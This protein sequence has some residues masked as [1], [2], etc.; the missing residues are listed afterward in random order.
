MNCWKA[1][2]ICWSIGGGIALAQSDRAE[3]PTV[4][5]GA[6]SRSAARVS[7]GAAQSAVNKVK[8]VRSRLSRFQRLLSLSAE[9]RENE[10]E[11]KSDKER[12]F[13]RR[14]LEKY[15]QMAKEDRETALQGLWV[16]YYVRE[17]VK[18]PGEARANALNVIPETER[19]LVENRLLKWDKLPPDLQ[20]EILAN[21]RTIR[22]VLELEGLSREEQKVAERR[23]PGSLRK[24]WDEKLQAW[25]ELPTERRESIYAHFKRF[26]E[27]S[28][29]ERS[30]VLETLSQQEREQAEKSL[31][32]VQQIDKLSPEEQAACL[33]SLGNFLETPPKSGKLYLYLEQLQRWNEMSVQEKDMLKKVRRVLAPGLTPPLPGVS[34]E[35]PRGQMKA[36]PAPPGAEPQKRSSRDKKLSF[37]EVPGPVQNTIKARGGTPEV[38]GITRVST[39]GQLA[40]S[41]ILKQDGKLV[42]LLIAPDG[43]EIED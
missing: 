17:L 13:L 6:A 3:Q 32:V 21:E 14:E 42:V 26:S 11:S 39:N 30:K 40:Y 28:P 43:S 9:E 2:L 35:P 36:A 33:D 15:D 12:A 4:L 18:H 10:L 7:S 1:Y 23:L 25:H 24:I 38:K 41:V 31:Q 34:A 16:W 19:K 37:A 29:R 20:Q 22:Y 27:L 5:P 8:E